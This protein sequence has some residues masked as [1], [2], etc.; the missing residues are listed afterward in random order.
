MVHI[1]S[2]TKCFAEPMQTFVALADKTRQTLAD[3][4]ALQVLK[5]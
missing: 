3:H 2:M 4:A 5:L 1:E